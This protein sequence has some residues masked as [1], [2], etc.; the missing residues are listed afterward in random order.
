MQD[1][2]SYAR[3][4][5]IGLVAVGVWVVL[6][7]AVSRSD[8]LLEGP[9]PLIPAM[10]FSVFGACF[11]LRRLAPDFRAWVDQLDLRLLVLYHFVRAPIGV[12]FLV[13]VDRGALTPVFGV[14]AGW[15]DIL[16]GVLALLAVLALPP[17]TPRKRGFLFA[18][19]L[20][21]LVDIL[22]VIS[23]AQRVIFFGE[24]REALLPLASFPSSLIPL[25]V[26]PGVLITHALVFLR[27]RGVGPAREP[28]GEP[29]S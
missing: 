21:G 7:V 17:D 9:R 11:L 18:W 23:T 24:G 20:I 4:R 12:Y 14:P 5:F 3:G 25:L 15:G 26:V 28:S 16:V 2:H 22:F 13:L 6:A 29:A 10:I 27:L 19:N 8:L 1:M